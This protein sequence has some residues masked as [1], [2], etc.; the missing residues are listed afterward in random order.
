MNVI[1]KASMTLYM[2]RYHEK[3]D[4]WIVMGISI[5]TH[6]IEDTEIFYDTLERD[7][8][9]IQRDYT[10]SGVAIIIAFLLAISMH[11]FLSYAT[12]F[13]VIAAIVV[14]SSYDDE[15]HP[16]MSKEE[17]DAVIR[18]DMEKLGTASAHTKMDS[19]P[20]TL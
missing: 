1:M 15:I 18:E 20:N 13:F 14:L 19:T 10:V 12:T 16:Y 7:K 5:D 9:R 4:Y 2:T 17:W 8:K 6:H 3:H 11:Y